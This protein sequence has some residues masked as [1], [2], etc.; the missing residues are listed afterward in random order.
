MFL[1]GKYFNLKCHRELNLFY[2]GSAQLW[3]LQRVCGTIIVTQH[4]L[5]L[6]DGNETTL[7]VYT[8]FVFHHNGDQVTYFFPRCET[9]TWY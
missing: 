8:W 6:Y 4:R 5:P 9:R 2:A 7:S 1:I 3:T